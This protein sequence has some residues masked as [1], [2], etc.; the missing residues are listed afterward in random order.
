MRFNHLFTTKAGQFILFKYVVYTLLTINIYLFSVNG[1]FTETIDTTAWVVVLGLFEWETRSMGSKYTN[2]LEPAIIALLSAFCYAVITYSAYSYFIE[3][4][5]LDLSNA[6]TWILI[7]L[8]LQYEIYSPNHYKRDG[9]T[10]INILKVALYT[11][12]FI[13]AV[14]WGVEGKALDFYDSF[15]WIL[16]FFVIEMNVFNFEHHHAEQD[17]QL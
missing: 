15:L 12:L 2:R 17:K 11:A 7:V 1:T 9:W 5:W 13:F 3:S 8:V 6:I 4:E 14:L 16:S 10:F